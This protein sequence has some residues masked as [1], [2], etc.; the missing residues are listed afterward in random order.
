EIKTHPPNDAAAPNDDASEKMKDPTVVYSSGRKGSIQGESAQ[1]TEGGQS[2]RRSSGSITMLKLK[3]KLSLGGNIANYQP[4]Q[5]EEPDDLE[6]PEN[7]VT[8]SEASLPQDQAVS[9]TSRLQP[10]LQNEGF[11]S[12]AQGT[13]CA[14][15]DE[16][17][18]FLDDSQRGKLPE[19]RQLSSE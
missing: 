16:S 15:D 6:G 14:T 13:P 19:K 4:V 10:L 7:K 2:R 18:N 17:D 8:V 9:S 3:R 11:V 5:N 1:G 12:S